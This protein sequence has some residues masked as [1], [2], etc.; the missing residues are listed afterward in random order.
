[1][2]IVKLFDFEGGL[3]GDGEGLAEGEEIEGLLLVDEFG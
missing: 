1:M 2:N 3:A